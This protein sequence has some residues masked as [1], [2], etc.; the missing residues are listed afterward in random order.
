[1]KKLSAIVAAAGTGVRLRSKTAKPYISINNK[2][3]L[4]YCLNVLG[5]SDKINDI[6]IS[7]EKSNI[8]RVKDLIKK[9]KLKKIKD[10]VA[11]GATRSASV[12]NGLKALDEETDYVLI[13]D[14]A[15]PFLTRDLIDR[16]FAAA[17][18]HKAV[19]CAVICSSTIKQA[20]KKLR[21]ISTLDRNS[22]WQ[23]QTPQVFSY[24]L[25]RCAYDKF[26]NKK[27]G[28][29]DDASLVEKLGQKVQIVPGNNLNI[30]ITTPADLKI[31][32]A[33]LSNKK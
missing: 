19:I 18:K 20:D 24:K 13:H 4:W 8:E 3:L 7:C 23:V 10:V 12:Y 6:I 29:F 16:C 2:P 15:R 22:L 31:A 27:S 21:V 11:G 14:G 28:A 25:I 33:I 17:L 1:M 9:F 32:R 5:K 26:K 30:K